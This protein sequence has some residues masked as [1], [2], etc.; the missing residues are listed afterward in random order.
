MNPP[1][2]W[3]TSGPGIFRDTQSVVRVSDAQI[4]FLEGE[5]AGSATGRTRLCAH[6]SNDSAVHEMLIALTAAS[7][8]QPHRHVGKSESFHMIA[9]EIDIVLFSTT[10]DITDVI[11]LAP[12]GQGRTFFYRLSSDLFH[13]VLVHGAHSSFHETTG[14]PFRREDTVFAEW[15]P[16]QQ[17]HEA[18]TDYQ[19]SL[20]A[21]V[22]T[23]KKQ[24]PS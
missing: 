14:G 23:W 17:S 3:Q 2:H 13:T 15:A 21:R 11:S 18:V 5:L 24:T 12:Y 22:A 16:D 6:A 4:A 19:Q 9:G 8:V 20:R 7:Y 10:G 1:E